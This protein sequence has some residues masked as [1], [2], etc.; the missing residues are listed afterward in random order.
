MVKVINIINN[1]LVTCILTIIAAGVNAQAVKH[2]VCHYDNN[3]GYYELINISFKALSAHKN[4]GDALPGEQIP[5]NP[6][7]IFDDSCQPIAASTCPCDFSSESL[8]TLGIDGSQESC[9]NDI[10]GQE[11]GIRVVGVSTS[12]WV[13][14][15]TTSP[16]CH[17]ST[18]GSQ[19]IY[20]P[21][22]FNSQEFEDCKSD[23]RLRAE[24]LGIDTVA[25]CL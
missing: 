13:T 7:Y 12:V 11:L 18:N 22:E 20:S 8:A 14:D 3:G 4:H 25:G 24:E 21:L 23:I 15:T 19:V 1:L 6:G 16:S 9:V 2:D 10:P 17:G 5:T